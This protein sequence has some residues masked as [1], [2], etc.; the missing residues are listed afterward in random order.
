MKNFFGENKTVLKMTI[1]I[2]AAVIAAMSV[3]GTRI[4]IEKKNKTYDI[5]LDYAEIE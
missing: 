5:V 3:I 2:L 4:G 1:L